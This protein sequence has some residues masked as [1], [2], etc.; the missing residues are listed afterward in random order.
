MK[1][2]KTISMLGLMTLMLV[3]CGNASDETAKP[4]TGETATEQPVGEKTELV[5]GSPNAHQAFAKT[6][7]EKFLADNNLAN[8]YSIKMVE[9]G[10]SDTGG[11]T[12]WSAA[13]APDLYAY[14]SDQT[15]KLY[16][17]GALA[18]IPEAY[19]TKIETDMGAEAANAGILGGEAYGYPYA[20][21][22]GYFL[23]YNTDYVSAE[24]AKTL[25]GILEACTAAKMKFGYALD[26]D[27][28]FF[29]IGTF[30]TFGA[31]YNVTLN[32]DGT[33]KSVTSTFAD[34]NGV[35]G[36]TLVKNLLA[37]ANVDTTHAGARSKAPTQANN[38][39]A[40]VEGSWNYNEFS[41]QVGD[42]LGV[43]KLPTATLDGET[44]N[45]AS[46]LGYK[47]YGVNPIKS[48][49]NTEKLSVLHQLAN[50]LVSEKV[51]EDRF[52][53]LTV[54]PTNTKVKALQKVTDSPLVK[55]LADQA[56][57]SVAQTVVPSNIWSACS[58]AIE[59][60]KADDADVA[61]IMKTYADSI[62]ASTSF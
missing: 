13:T 7:A 1:R 16:A 10:E 19:A 28:S 47:L 36:G 26:T 29:S 25:D 52:D 31:R 35:K 3:G 20:G 42:K 27:S 54:V 57:F 60:L 58:T 59:S 5:I 18:A 46:F 48:A 2:M 50:Y 8:T 53:Q 14:A 43:A 37:N 9:L 11:V 61:T 32:T 56:Q 21:D 17:K 62:A 51:Q 4:A 44:K 40:V 30:M 41:K 34:A 49:G 33:L 38:F 24:Q 15:G 12:D 22:N 45:L 23:Y 55:A 6:A 39:C